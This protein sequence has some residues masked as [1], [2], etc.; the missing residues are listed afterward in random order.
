MAQRF[1]HLR[2][3]ALI[4]I[5]EKNVTHP[6]RTK[7]QRFDALHHL[8]MTAHGRGRSAGMGFQRQNRTDSECFWLKQALKKWDDA[9]RKDEESATSVVKRASTKRSVNHNSSCSS[10]HCFR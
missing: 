4:R 10:G 9:P 8:E 1:E 3:V 7:V 2:H 5:V 6:E